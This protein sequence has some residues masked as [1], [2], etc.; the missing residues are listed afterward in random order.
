VAMSAT[1]SPGTRL[2]AETVPNRDTVE[3]HPDRRA[4]LRRQGC[5]QRDEEQKSNHG[6]PPGKTEKPAQNPG[7]D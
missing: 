7:R 6:P 5:D 3:E 4:G 1:R 2:M